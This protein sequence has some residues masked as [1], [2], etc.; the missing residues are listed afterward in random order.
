MAKKLGLISS[1][2]CIFRPTAVPKTIKTDLSDRKKKQLWQFLQHKNR[3][4]NRRK[5]ID[6]P[7][8]Y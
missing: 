5:G 6:I 3:Y 1:L 2:K 8:K 4:T 7:L